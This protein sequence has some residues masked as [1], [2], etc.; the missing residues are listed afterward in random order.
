M[1]LRDLIDGNGVHGEGKD[2][3]FGFRGRMDAAH[4]HLT[5]AVQLIG[6]GGRGV[7][8]V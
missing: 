6:A 8:A 1:E 3:I 2:L 5:G 7:V 4:K